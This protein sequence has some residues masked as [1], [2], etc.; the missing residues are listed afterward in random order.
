MICFVLFYNNFILL[1]FCFVQTRIQQKED[2]LQKYVELLDK[3]REVIMG[4]I[5]S[6]IIER[7]GFVLYIDV[8]GN[9]SLFQSTLITYHWQ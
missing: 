3:A 9:V 6:D 8:S 2:A 7:L 1:T 4:L 5:G